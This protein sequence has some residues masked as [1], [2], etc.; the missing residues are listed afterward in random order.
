MGSAEESAFGDMLCSYCSSL[1]RIKEGEVA[2]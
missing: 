1:K 2:L